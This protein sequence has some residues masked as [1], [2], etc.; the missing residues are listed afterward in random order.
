VRTTQH[1]KPEIIRNMDVVKFLQRL[2]MHGVALKM[3]MNRD[4][5]QVSG[6]FGYK[7]DLSYA[8]GEMAGSGAKN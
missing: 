7:R 6:W 3:L 8:G 2:R 4:I 5:M 1:A